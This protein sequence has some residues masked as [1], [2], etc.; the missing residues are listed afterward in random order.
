MHYP[1]TF[2]QSQKPW[3]CSKKSV[4]ILLMIIVSGFPGIQYVF[5]QDNSVSKLSHFKGNVSITQNGLSLIPAFSL[6]RPAAVLEMSL[7]GERLSFDPE[8]RFALDGQPWSFIFWWR[9]KI[10]KSEKF[11]LHAGS[12]PSFIFR[13]SQVING[14]GQVVESLESLRF[15]ASE[16]VPTYNLTPKTKLSFVYLIARNLGKLPTEVNQFVAINGSFNQVRLT[17][18][19][20]VSLKPQFF[21]LKM[22]EKDGTYISSIFSVGKR[23]F[24]VSLGSIVSRKINSEI[25][26]KDWIYNVS[27]IYSF[28]NDYI[29]RNNP[30]I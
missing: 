30:V 15:L 2:L 23:D 14:N 5:G 25:A 13:N 6:G 17:E 3:S 27:L 12:H 4:L 9:Y 22:N 10:I 16:I 26:G 24:P 18:S 7:G 19:L 21:Y 1:F 28:N 11:N 8:L 20:Y 29:K